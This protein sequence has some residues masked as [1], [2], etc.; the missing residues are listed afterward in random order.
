[1]GRIALSL[2]VAFGLLLAGRPPLARAAAETDP[3]VA[4]GAERLPEAVPAPDEVFL[5][6][7]NREVRLRDLRGRVVLLGFFTT[8]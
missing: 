1:M 2:A 4:M 7:D 5:T 8:S 6:L 3:F